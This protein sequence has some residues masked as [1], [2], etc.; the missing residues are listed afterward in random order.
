MF[1]IALLFTLLLLCVV[2]DFKSRRIPNSLICVGLLFGPLLSAMGLNGEITFA[3]SVAGVLSG[4]LLLLPIY[5]LGKMGAGD[6]KLLAMC[7]GFL[8]AKLT[9][10][11]GLCT[12][13]AG[14]FLAL[15]W[16]SLVKRI[17]IQDKRYPYAAAI[18]VGTAMAPYLQFK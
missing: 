2:S 7:G 3:Q 4:L 16:I 14:G 17:P 6:V 12:F 15:I 9:L 11:A 8:G 1:A 18:A 13:F 5:M 10:M